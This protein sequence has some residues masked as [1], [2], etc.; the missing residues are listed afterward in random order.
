[1]TEK[2]FD[3]KDA[4]SR[5]K[6]LA[7]KVRDLVTRGKKAGAAEVRRER[8]KPPIGKDDGRRKRSTGR[9]AVFNTKLKPE[10]RAKIFALAQKQGVAAA[11]VIEQLLE[12]WETSPKR[13]A[14]G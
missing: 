12:H 9:T 13:G 8:E 2:G 11:A 1:M 6:S 10:V 5:F 7:P 3:E 4:W 14:K